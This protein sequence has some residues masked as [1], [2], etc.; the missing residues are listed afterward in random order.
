MKDITVTI[1][2]DGRTLQDALALWMKVSRR[3]A[4]QHIDARVVW[5]NDRCVWMARHTVKAGDRVRVAGAV[6]S[7]T[8]KASVPR[9]VKIL[10]EDDDFMVVDKPAGMLTNASDSSAEAVVREQ[11]GLP[12]IQAVHRLDRDTSGCLLMAK[13]KRAFEAAVNIF[14]EHRIKKTYR[15]IVYGRWEADAST[16]DLPVDGKRAL[17]QVSCVRATDVA[18]Y[19]VLHIET[20]RT[21]QIRQHLAMARHPVVGDREYGPKQVRDATLQGVTRAMLHAAELVMDHPTCEGELRVFSP[22]PTDFHKWLG[23][24]RLG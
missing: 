16:I 7:P 20:G 3:V 22:I 6:A 18:S 10:F 8:A 13:S 5:V 24:L 1:K 2:D 19:L 14:K 15:A 12:D 11:K 21:H 4:K 23:A 17:T 9:K